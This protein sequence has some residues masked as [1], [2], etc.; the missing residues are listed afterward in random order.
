MFITERETHAMIHEVSL[1]L[2]NEYQ[3]VIIHQPTKSSRRN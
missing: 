3:H 1:K 2:S